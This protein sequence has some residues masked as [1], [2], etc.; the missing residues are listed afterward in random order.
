MTRKLKGAI[1]LART[2]P[3]EAQDAVA[4][5]VFVYL[6]SAVENDE[7]DEIGLTETLGTNRNCFVGQ[8]KIRHLAEAVA[9]CQVGTDDFNVAIFEDVANVA[10]LC[11]FHT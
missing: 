8:N 3:D 10:R 4:A 11:V 5:A 9:C 2:L 7:R 6:S 1:E